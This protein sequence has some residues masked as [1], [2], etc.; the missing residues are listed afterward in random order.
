MV[1]MLERHVR[2]IGEQY[3]AA[4]PDRRDRGARQV[5]KTTLARQLV[6]NTGATYV[7][8]D[9][10]AD[11]V[12]NRDAAL[13]QSGHQSACLL[14]LIRLIAANQGGELV[15]ARLAEQ[16]SLPATSITPYLDVLKGIFA[17]EELP[18]WVA[19]LAAREIGRRKVAVAD[20]A[21]G[22]WFAGL[23][24][25]WLQPVTAEALGVLSRRLSLSS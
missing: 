8:L 25:A 23:T 24:V 5:G 17:I 9:G 13:L 11:R 22:L 7:T 12:L 14:A 2:A 3:L 15:K 6:A 10:Y 18:P 20:S 16:A 19:S 1:E 21:L 4:F